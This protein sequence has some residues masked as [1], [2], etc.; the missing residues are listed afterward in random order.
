[1]TQS[2]TDPKQS[3]D[4]MNQRDTVHV[5]FIFFNYKFIANIEIDLLYR[6]RKG[7]K[8]WMSSS[9]ATEKGNWIKARGQDIIPIVQIS[10]SVPPPFSHR[11]QRGEWHLSLTAGLIVWPLVHSVVRDG[12]MQALTF[13]IKWL[14]CLTSSPASP[15]VPY[16][17]VYVTKLILQTWVKD[18]W[19]EI[20]TLWFERLICPGLRTRW[21]GFALF[22][23]IKLAPLCQA[24]SINAETYFW[25]DFSLYIDP[26]PLDKSHDTLVK[27]PD[28][29]S[30]A[31]VEGT[32]PRA[33]AFKIKVSK[34]RRGEK[35]KN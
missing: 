26:V 13:Q 22:L 12:H 17:D 4:P 34:G 14:K 29:D 25:K 35:I 16:L 24:G 5:V 8:T 10:V 32:L 18:V 28:W 2:N 11:D 27:C 19:I 23:T 15:C 33:A 21:V 7:T 20:T 30:A 6:N 3:S 9:S 1:M 31:T